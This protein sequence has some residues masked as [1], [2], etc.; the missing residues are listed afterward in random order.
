MDYVAIIPA[1][2]GSKR[3][4]G[5][6]LALLGG[7]SLLDHSIDYAL[8]N[9]RFLGEILV[10]SDDEKILSAAEKRGV[11]TLE[12]PAEYATDNATTASALRH[13]VNLLPELPKHVVLLQVTNPLRPKGLMHE[14]LECYE[15]SRRS[16]LMT[17]SRLD[18]KLGTISDQRFHPSNYSFGQRSQELEPQYYEN[19]LL[20]IS[21]LSLIQKEQV[22]DQHSFPLEVK[23]R[24][25]DIDIDEPADLELAE[26]YYKLY[27]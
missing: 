10:T 2:G 5:K 3:F 22:M 8:E 15:Q 1:R 13:A 16:S 17:V 12:R 6:N 26:L 24:F 4:P 21:S 11:N 7:K 27:E 18:K 9:E 14:A 25:G 20:Y 19:G 23:H